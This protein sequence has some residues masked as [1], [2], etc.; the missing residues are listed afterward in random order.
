MSKKIN[1][2]IIG[3]NFGYKVIYKSLANIKNLKVTAFCYKERKEI[4]Q[5]KNVIFFNNYKELIKNKNVH[6]VIITSPPITHK[7]IISLCIKYNKMFI[8]EKPVGTSEYSLLSLKKKIDEKNILCLVNYEYVQIKSFLLL[9]K[10]I[11]KKYPKKIDI[12]WN[13]KNFSNTSNWKKKHS[14]G[15]NIY[16]N[17]ICHV[18]YYIENIFGIIVVFKVNKKNSR[19]V[20]IKFFLNNK[21]EI[22][23]RLKKYN[24]KERFKPIHRIKIFYDKFF[25]NLESPTSKVSDKFSLEK[26]LK[27]TRKT[28]FKEGG[29]DDFRFLPSQ[30]NIKKF[31]RN[32][33]LCKKS[34]PNL[35]SAIRIH[36]IIRKIKNSQVNKKIKI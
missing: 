5:D 28:I 22:N 3:K 21:I 30:R 34:S 23:F 35:N 33:S 4:I 13:I 24:Q 8:C 25:Y 36:R 7:N 16:F 32:I 9:K 10:I 14:L 1:V 27:K 17:Y 20:Q 11:N 26:V 2:G 31:I 6:L 18:L 15:G 29:D 19:Q 12:V